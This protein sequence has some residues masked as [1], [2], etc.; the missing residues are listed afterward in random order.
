MN[1]TEQLKL[2]AYLDGE[3]TG[4]E[5]DEVAELL[6]KRDDAR[7]LLAELQHTRAA[8]RGNEPARRL[9]CSREF[10][11]SRLERELA[12]SVQEDGPAP[13][14]NLLHWLRGHLRTVVG[15]GM[16]VALLALTLTL[17]SAGPAAAESEW[18]VLHP[19]TGMVSLRDYQSGITVVML[20][21]RTTPGFTSGD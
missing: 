6:D 1:E 11:W 14:V 10:Y 21:D 19:Q 3:L 7:E 20:Y 15:T 5:R 4:R 12:G 8:I 18:E 9:D 13:A 2:Q 16:A 17:F